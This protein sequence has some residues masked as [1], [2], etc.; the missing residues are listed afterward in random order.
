MNP[1]ATSEADRVIDRL[2]G[3]SKT[4]ALC[5]VTPQ[6]VWQWRKN[7]IPKV[8]RKFLLA[9]RPDAFDQ[10]DQHHQPESQPQ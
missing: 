10:A 5:E 9:I 6:A 4:A 8:Q 3:N 1:T 2:G 7:G